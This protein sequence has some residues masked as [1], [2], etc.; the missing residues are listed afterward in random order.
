M[1]P[2]WD[3]EKVVKHSNLI[4]MFEDSTAGGGFFVSEP[5][6]GGSSQL[7]SG[8]EQWLVRPISRVSLVINWL[9]PLLT[10]HL[11][12]GVILQVEE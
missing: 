11:L 4:S 6:L 12:S 3:L 8:Y 9:Y 5:L 2:T 1:D 10:S 7:E